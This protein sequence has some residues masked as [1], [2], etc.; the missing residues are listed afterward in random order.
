M[1][2]IFITSASLFAVLPLFAYYGEPDLTDFIPG[3]IIF[4]YLAGFVLQIVLIIKFWAMANNISKIR[5]QYCHESRWNS[6]SFSIRDIYL[7]EGSE[8]ASIHLN[9]LLCDKLE[10]I[11]NASYPKKNRQEWFSDEYQKTLEKYSRYYNAIGCEIPSRFVG[12]TYDR[13]VKFGE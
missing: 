11:Y 9:G 13:Y 8:A 5:T 12:L 1:K 4:L 10:S 2:K 7:R 3:W 6:E